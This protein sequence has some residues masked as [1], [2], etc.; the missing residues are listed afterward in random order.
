MN[1]PLVTMRMRLMP[2]MQAML[3]STCSIIGLP[4]LRSGCA[5]GSSGL[6][7][8]SVKG[9]KRVAKPAANTIR[10]IPPVCAMRVAHY[11]MPPRM[12]RANSSRDS[13]GE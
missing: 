7:R 4:P 9:Y 2:G 5:T 1:L 10:W 6:G 8:V 11:P 13:L 3:S 12:W